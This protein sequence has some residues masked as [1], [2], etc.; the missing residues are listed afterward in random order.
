MSVPA[1]N[2]VAWF[3]IGTDQPGEVKEF[4]GQLFGWTS[5][6]N[7]NLPGVNYHAVATG[8][9]PRPSGGVWESDGKFPNYA[10]F[11]VLVQDVAATVEQA[12]RLGGKVLMPPVTDAAGVTFAR[13]EDS[14]G[15]HFG[16]FYMPAP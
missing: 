14:T 16:V 6:L 15:N 7:T 10:I 1:L 9:A 12:V 13:L 5:S 2:S 4:Y 3:E 8:D 11:Y